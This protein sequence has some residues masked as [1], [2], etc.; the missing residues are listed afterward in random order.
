[1]GFWVSFALPSAAK[2]LIA[3]AK[4]RRDDRIMA[5]YQGEEGARLRQYEAAR[6]P[7]PKLTGEEKPAMAQDARGDYLVIFRPDKERRLSTLATALTSAVPHDAP[8]LQPKEEY[9]E[10][11]KEIFCD[12]WAIVQTI[13]GLRETT[14]GGRYLRELGIERGDH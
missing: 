4:A 5:E 7:V 9:I 12:G 10:I 8:E 3:A 11:G 1:V 13:S 14:D 2:D 6:P